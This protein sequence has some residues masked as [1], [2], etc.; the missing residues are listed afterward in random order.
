MVMNNDLH[1]SE[2]ETLDKKDQYNEYLLTSLRTMWG[3]DMDTIQ[4]RFGLN[5][6]KYTQRIADI[7]LQ[8]GEL[9]KD[10]SIIRLTEKGIFLADYVVREFF[11]LNDPE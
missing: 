8:T 2:Y 6:V 11:I 10:G 1:F 4:Q 9:I 5:Y 3:I 7:F